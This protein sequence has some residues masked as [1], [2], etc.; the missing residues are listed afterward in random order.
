MRD[1]LVVPKWSAGESAA[2]VA[3]DVLRGL[4]SVEPATSPYL[5][6]LYAEGARRVGFRGSV[7]VP[8][9]RGTGREAEA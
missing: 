2:D 3:T 4:H 8:G 1:Y 6:A 7:P 9:R 5:W